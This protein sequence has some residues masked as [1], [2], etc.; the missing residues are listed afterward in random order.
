MIG[1]E[2]LWFRGLRVFRFIDLLDL[3]VV[4]WICCGLWVFVLL[5]YFELFGVASVD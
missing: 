5:F 3:G 1:Y 2:G 4:C